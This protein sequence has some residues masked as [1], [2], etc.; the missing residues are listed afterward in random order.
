MPIYAAPTII[1]PAPF[2]VRMK[3]IKTSLNCL[4][5]AMSGKLGLIYDDSRIPVKKSLADKVLI[6]VVDPATAL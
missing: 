3:Y 5:I 1:D 2:V 6:S 4:T